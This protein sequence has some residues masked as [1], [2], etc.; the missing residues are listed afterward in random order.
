MLMHS[1]QLFRNHKKSMYDFIEVGKEGGAGC[2]L[3][4]RAEK[5]H[6]IFMFR[7]VVE[8]RSLPQMTAKHGLNLIV[9]LSKF[10]T[11]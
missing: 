11:E 4:L 8:Q 2:S 6:F 3:D 9:V 7:N 10:V 1:N 5:T